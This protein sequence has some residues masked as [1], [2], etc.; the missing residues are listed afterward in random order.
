MR[1]GT[2]QG[3]ISDLKLKKTSS[4][5]SRTK[6]I[7]L[8]EDTVTKHTKQKRMQITATQVYLNLYQAE[9][10]VQQRTQIRK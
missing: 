1:R 3:E 6:D 7:M 8:A 5:L 10:P 9:I 2:I 4:Q